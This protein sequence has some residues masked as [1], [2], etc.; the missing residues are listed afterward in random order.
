MVVIHLGNM[1]K[2]KIIAEIG[3]NHSGKLENAKKLIQAAKDSGCDYGKL[4]TY[5]TEKVK[6]DSPILIY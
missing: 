1:Q 3:I 4:Q 5:I 2:V 6:S